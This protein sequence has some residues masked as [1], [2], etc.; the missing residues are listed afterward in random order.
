MTSLVPLMLG[1]VLRA[2][3]PKKERC[4]YIGNFLADHHMMCQGPSDQG[5]KDPSVAASMRE[6]APASRMP[7]RKGRSVLRRRAR[8]NSYSFTRSRTDL[9]LPWRNSDPFHLDEGSRLFLNAGQGYYIM[10]MKLALRDLPS[11]DEFRTL[12]SR[13]KITGWDTRITPTFSQNMAGSFGLGGAN[14]VRNPM[15]DMEM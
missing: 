1:P 8:A 14:G 10:Q 4:L 2:I 13:Y 3:C 11:Y 12:F 9:I 7:S 15:P 5:S 6:H